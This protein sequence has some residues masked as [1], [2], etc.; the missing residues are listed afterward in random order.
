MDISFAWRK[1]RSSIA[2]VSVATLLASLI[3][4]SGVAQAGTTFTDVPDDHYAAEAIEA[5]AT[6]GVIGGYGNGT[7]GPNDKMSRA[8]L[9]KVIVGAFDLDTSAAASYDTGFT[10]LPTGDLA[11]FVKAAAQL[12]IMTGYADGTNRFGSN[13][14]VERQDLAVVLHRVLGLTEMTDGGPHFPDVD[15]GA[16]YYGA[17][18]TMWWYQVVNGYNNGKFGTGDE[19]IRADATLMI[20]R[21]TGT[22]TLRDVTEEPTEPDEETSSDGTLVVELS[23]DTPDG[24]TLPDKATSVAMA[25]WD[26]SAEGDDVELDSLVVHQNSIGSLASSHNVYLYEGS[27]RLTN[28]SAVNTSTRDVT[29]NNLNLAIEKGDTRTITV[30]MDVGDNG[31]TNVEIAFEIEDADAVGTNAS[32]VEGDFAL[33]GETFEV[34]AGTDAG[35]ITIEKTGTITNPKVGEDDVVVS[36]FKLSTSG[37]GAS[38]EEFGLYGSGSVSTADLQDFKLYVS[39]DDAEPLA[40]AEMVDDQDVARFILD[41]PY[42]IEKGGSKTFYVTT[43]FNTGRTDDTVKFYVDENTDVLAT[44]DK[45]GF[46]LQVTRT[47][48]DGD[49]CTTTAGDCSYSVLEGGDI[50]ISSSGPSAKDIAINGDNVHVMDFSIAAVSDMTFKNFSIALTA[51]ESSDTTE[52][53]LAAAST[54]NFTDIRIINTKDGSTVWGPIDSDQLV[55]TDGGATAIDET[56]DAAKAYYLF[57]DDL[58]MEAGEELDLAIVLDVENTTTLDG[59][60]LVGSLELGS[61]YPELRD[62][63]NKVLTNTSVLVPASDIASKTMTLKSPGLTFAV[64]STVGS[65]TYVKGSDDVTFACFSVQA[66]QASDVELDGLTLTGSF[67]ENNDGAYDIDGSDNGVNL[68][69]IVGS[70]S[71]QDDEGNEIAAA[72]SVSTTNVVQF[73][74]MNYVIDSGDTVPVCV[75]GDISDN[76]F[77]SSTVDKVAFGINATSD[78]T[79]VDEDGNN[80]SSSQIV[81]ASSLNVSATAPSVVA[82]VSRG[83]TLTFGVHGDTAREDIVI[84]GSTGVSTSKFQIT[85]T[86]EPFIVKQLALSNRQSAFTAA[87]IGDYDDNISK[88]YLT[89]QNAEGTSETATGFLT[90]GTA[91]FSGLD[92]YVGK[93]MDVVVTVT[94]DLKTIATTADAGTFVDLALTFENLEAQAQGSGEVYKVDQLDAGDGDLSIGTISYS[95][96]LTFLVDGAVTA[97]TLG[98]TFT[99]AADDG[100]GAD[101]TTVQ[102]PLGTIVCFDED[103]GGTCATESVAFI[104]AYS[105]GATEDTYTAR[106]ADDAGGAI[107]DNSNILYAQPGTGFFT[108]TNQMVVYETKPLVTLASTSPSGSRSL[109][110]TDTPFIF[111]VEN[112]GDADYASKLQIRAAQVNDASTTGAD[113]QATALAGTFTAT[114]SVSAPTSG[115]IGNSAYIRE[116]SGGTD[117]ASIIYTFGTNADL[118][119]YNGISFW[120]RASEA[121]NTI[122]LTINDTAGTDQTVASGTMTA[123]TWQFVDLSFAGIASTDLDVISTLTWAVTDASAVNAATYDLDRVV[124][125]YEKITV[126]ATSDADF[127]TNSASSADNLVAYL[128]EGGSTVATG[129]FYSST[130]GADASTTSVT[131]YPQQDTDATIEVAAESS[132]TFTLQTDT[133]LL[134]HEDAASDDNVTFS[135]DLGTSTAGTVTAGDFWWYETNATVKWLGQV[136]NSTLNSNTLTY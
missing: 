47:A 43:S 81:G 10:D 3:S 14:P 127:D 11:L 132:K 59:M 122:T 29:F 61:T 85:G 1:F 134:L 118:S 117:A 69:V 111:K 19:V 2:T 26:F 64:A 45:Y 95:D 65:D 39:G 46:G 121:A 48:F 131:F 77:Q 92:I 80:L 91:E 98:G 133:S 90:N 78:V 105:D 50:T 23:E 51:S 54:A 9:A 89:Y 53:L 125:Y 102:L 55:T 38:I 52:G 63:N 87:A 16:Y 97:P 109:S 108:S 84:A 100:A 135:I 129:Y 93:D 18:E 116:T 22:L 70:V 41:E 21:A 57:T 128:K 101:A 35:T 58:S 4:F 114:D 56:T 130:Q 20:Y 5:L 60:T 75:V 66:N 86:D 25:S 115:G 67:D 96:G 136:A 112:K 33:K 27:T 30:R 120:V 113:F 94:A 106:L 24:E 88:V 73:T 49:S 17:V 72:Q 79:A 37:E 13:D 6:D 83:G 7:F 123:A 15:D 107:A 34:A 126:D 36:R 42:V 8:Q 99:F 119:G 62:A 28:G 44:G 76:A 40:T 124:L 31:T 74:N 110:T 71:L 12:G 68:N 32:D 104:T 103:A 82:T